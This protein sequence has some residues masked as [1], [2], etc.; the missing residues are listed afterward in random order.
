MASSFLNCR[1]G[2]LPFKYLG[3]PIGA[4]PNCEATWDPLIDHIKKRLF[5]WRNKFISF[6]GRI[7]LINSVLNAI[8]IF[9]LSFLKLPNKV[10]KKIVKIQREFLWGGVKGGKKICWVKWETVCKEKCKGGLGVRDVKIV[11]LSLLTK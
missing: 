1:L 10:W 7:V 4:N 2:S 3:L 8:P 9:H 6:G 5:S 11:N